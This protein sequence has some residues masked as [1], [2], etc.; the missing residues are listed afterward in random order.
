MTQV[1]LQDLKSKYSKPMICKTISEALDIMMYDQYTN[2]QIIDL[3][4]GM[5]YQ[6]DQEFEL[7]LKA[8]IE[9]Y[10]DY[11]TDEA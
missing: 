8:R 10:Q 4:L 1:L 6:Y 5:V 2:G 3:K 7:M 9:E 11:V